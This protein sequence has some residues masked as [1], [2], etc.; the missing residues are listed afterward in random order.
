MGRQ[1]K[2]VIQELMHVFNYVA[3]QLP[4]RQLMYSLL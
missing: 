2:H 3:G 1:L 4:R